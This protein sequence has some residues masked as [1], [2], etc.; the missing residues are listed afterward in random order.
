VDG[1]SGNWIAQFPTPPTIT[2]A[3][4]RGDPAEWRTIRIENIALDHLA[5]CEFQWSG[6]GEIWI[7][8]V[9]YYTECSFDVVA[10]DFDTNINEITAAAQVPAYGNGR[11]DGFTIADEPW[12]AMMIPTAHVR[13]HL[14]GLTPTYQSKFWLNPARINAHTTH[15]MLD[16]LD[17]VDIDIYPYESG[18]TEMADTGAFQGH[19]QTTVV[20]LLRDFQNVNGLYYQREMGSTVQ[21]FWNEG[22]VWRYPSAD[23]LL[24]QVNLSLAYGSKSIWYYL[25]TGEDTYHGILDG[26]GNIVNTELYNAVR[27]INTRLTGNWGTTL[28]ALNYR[29]GF[30]RHEDTL[31][32]TPPDLNVASVDPFGHVRDI[33]SSPNP[34]GSNPDA[35]DATYVELTRFEDAT[36]A[37]YLYILN[38][39]TTR[40]N[41]IFVHMN[42]PDP[43]G[44]P[45]PSLTIMDM[46]DARYQV[47]CSAAP[48]HHHYAPAEAKLLR[49]TDGIWTTPTEINTSLEVMEGAAWVVNTEVTIN[50]GATVTVQEGGQII[51]EQGGALVLNGGSI[52]CMGSGQI[53]TMHASAITG[54]GILV[55]PNLKIEG[56]LIIHPSSVVLVLGGG[57]FDFV[58]GS[59]RMLI[60]LGQLLFE[61]DDCTVTFGDIEETRVSQNG[62]LSYSGGITVEKLMHINVWEQGTLSVIGVD[63]TH[64]CRLQLKAGAEI[65]SE[66]TFDA[67]YATFEGAPILPDGNEQW[68]GILVSGPNARISMNHALIKDIHCE[69]DMQGTG[70]HFFAASNAG[71]RIENTRILRENQ[72]EKLGDGIFLQPWQTDQSYVELQCVETLD[73][74]WTG[75]TS[76]SSECNA[77]GLTTKFNNRGV[78]AHLTGN[79]LYLYQSRLEDN[80]NEGL[81]AEKGGGFNMVTFGKYGSAPDG[82][83]SIT[84]NGIVQIHL[85]GTYL[86]GGLSNL[87]DNNDI[88]H[89]SPA[90][91]RMIVDSGGLANV[92]RNYWL[93]PTP[94]PSMFQIISGSCNRTPHLAQS[95]LPE[96]MECF[97]L[98]KSGR[99]SVLPPINLSTLME[100]GL[101]GRMNEVHAFV[102]AGIAA[103]GSVQNRVRL[104]KALLATEIAHAREYPDS[105]ATAFNRVGSF[106]RQNA[107]GLTA[108]PAALVALRAELYT[109]FGMPDSANVEYQMLATSFP[110]SDEYRTTLPSK[111]INAF[112]RQDSLAIDNVIAEMSVAGCDSSVLRNAGSERRAY[113]R[114]RK[115]SIIPKRSDLDASAG[116]IPDAIRFIA[117]P[118][119]ARGEVTVTCILPEPAHIRITLYSIDGKEIRSLYSGERDAGTFTLRDTVRDLIPGAYLYRAVSRHHSGSARIL[120]LR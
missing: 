27:S 47:V 81:Y 95:Y 107:A 73:D 83:N 70:I 92:T 46:A 38:R 78:G 63:E 10:G 36:G 119:P 20:D 29:E 42:T 98:S 4:L 105:M 57:T 48:F 86:N 75:L 117:S 3:D 15:T 69:P 26:N 53:R 19:L 14:A 101:N 18:I 17:A 106:L 82:F 71:N 80:L 49:I 62:L 96:E 91:L 85:I 76:V 87:N 52:T 37:D 116:V 50:T 32:G 30:S 28:S 74:W 77:T 100:Y 34:D 103:G 104:L 89:S 66:S 39:R 90:V 118:N 43:S 16:V 93:T 102:N 33:V 60:V 56:E 65:N 61:C 59:P 21:T 41:N 9:D 8:R 58:A 51:I 11:I 108:A 112:N 79:V 88:G 97:S 120:V 44:G 54:S 113:Y 45:T 22:D 13:N 5:M 115:N 35:E 68:E 114:C 72:L 25:L 55:T 12:A 1:K 31:S 6:Q 67:N 110:G 99:H 24:L 23:E 64:R 94:T 111:L 7:D 2:E 40:D 84:G 109:W